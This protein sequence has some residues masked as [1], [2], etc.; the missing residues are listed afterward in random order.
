MFMVC[1]WWVGGQR[2]VL[3][4]WL[5]RIGG[6]AEVVDGGLRRDGGHRRGGV[7]GV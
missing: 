6:G 2:L 5:V 7:E 3:H 4:R 1:C